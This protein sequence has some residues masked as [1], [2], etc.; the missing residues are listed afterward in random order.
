MLRDFTSGASDKEV[1]LHSTQVE[2]EI[3]VLTP[4]PSILRTDHIFFLSLNFFVSFH[5][6]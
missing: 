2:L 1:Q 6:E 3:H 4:K 5:T